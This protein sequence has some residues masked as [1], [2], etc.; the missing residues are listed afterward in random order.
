MMTNH[1]LQVTDSLLDY[2]EDKFL[3]RRENISGHAHYELS[4]DLLLAP[5]VKARDEARKKAAEQEAR[6]K[7]KE[8]Q[9][10]AEQREKEARLEAEKERELRIKENERRIKYR[11]VAFIAGLAFIVATVLGILTLMKSI[12]VKKKSDEIQQQKDKTEAALKQIIE[13]RKKELFNLINLDEKAGFYQSAEKIRSL[14][15]EVEVLEDI[16]PVAL[17]K[18][19]EKLKL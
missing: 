4:H 18:I 17:D 5:V 6:N 12:E 9:L 2:L 19:I 7:A 3:L 14:L 1:H 13:T 11:N 8:Q 10:A 15:R 16:E